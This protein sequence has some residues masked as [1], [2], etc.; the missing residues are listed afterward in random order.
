MKKNIYIL[1]CLLFTVYCL[2][3]FSCAKDKSAE[4]TTDL[5][6][7]Y[8]PDDV[9]RYVIYDV[10]SIWQDDP[11]SFHDTTRY[12]LKEVIAAIFLDNSGRPTLRIERF[13]KMYNDSIP[14]DSMNWIGPK[15]W[16]VNRTQ[17]TLEKKEENITYLKLVFPAREG[18]QWN[19][20]AYNT[21]GQKEY[22]I[23]S[24]DQAE[25]INSI[26]FD[27][28]VTVKQ[29]E[30]I[31]FIQ[32]RYEI[33]KFARNVGLIYK[34]RDSIYDGGTADTVGYTFT[35]KIVSYGK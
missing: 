2:L 1:F 29:F 32:Y 27:S 34:E 31:D 14:Y 7:N 8:F 9:G 11:A 10:D 30:Q 13:I 17:S 28:V 35:Q 12:L 5:G 26:N 6:H 20:N 33:E 21:L 23:I 25:S 19:G 22:E 24:V 18:K 3:L 4:S 16:T 15:V